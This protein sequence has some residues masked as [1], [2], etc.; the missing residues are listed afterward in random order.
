MEAALRTKRS[1]LGED[2]LGPF[3]N[4][5]AAWTSP[6]SLKRLTAGDVQRAQKEAGEDLEDVRKDSNLCGCNGREVLR[7]LWA[8]VCMVV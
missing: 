7:A 6:N 2:P 4:M 5:L 1:A 8:N 3:Q